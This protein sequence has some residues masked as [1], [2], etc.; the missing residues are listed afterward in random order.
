METE[1]PM[2]TGRG[3]IN[4]EDHGNPELVI[5]PKGVLKKK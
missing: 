5:K 4:D 1:A 2:N 3:L